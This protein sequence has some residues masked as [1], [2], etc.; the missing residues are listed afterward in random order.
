MGAHTLKSCLH[1][2]NIVARERRVSFCS[3]ECRFWHK[4]AKA[5][6]DECWLWTGTTPAFGHGQFVLNGRRIYSH[7]HSWELVNGPL[8]EGDDVCVLHKCDVPAC[9]NPDHLFVGSRKENLADMRRKGRGARPPR[10]VGSRHHSAKLTED[11]VR[12]IRAS[13]EPPLTL[14]KH[15]GIN[16]VSL[17]RILNRRS[18]T[19]I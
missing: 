1:C 17:Y 16:H 9:V 4:V 10:L 11:D 12:A 13:S 3:D 15:Y 14:A 7:R 5:A 2:G 8:A 19:H 6:P 18:W